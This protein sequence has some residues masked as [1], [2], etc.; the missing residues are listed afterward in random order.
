MNSD[1]VLV[2]VT[3]QQNKAQVE[4]MLHENNDLLPFLHNDNA[5]IIVA[6]YASFVKQSHV[7]FA[8]YY[9]YVICFEAQ[10]ATN[11][12]LGKLFSDSILIGFTSASEIKQGWFKDAHCVFSYTIGQAIE[13]GERKPE[14]EKQYAK[15]VEGFCMRFLQ[16]FSNVELNNGQ[17]DDV[18]FIGKVGQTR[19]FVEYKIYRNRWIPRQ[20]LDK[21]VKNMQKHIDDHHAVSLILVFGEV[22]EEYKKEIFDNESV[23]I[24]DI[25]NILYYVKKS[26]DLYDELAGLAYFAISDIV[27]VPPYGWKLDNNNINNDIDESILP[28]FKS[29]LMRCK[30]G[31]NSAQVY[32]SICEKII[33][34]LFGEEFSLCLPQHKTKDNLFRMDAICSLKGTSAFWKLLIQHYNTRFVVFEFKNYSTLLQQNLIFVTEKYLF[35]AALRNVAIIISR[36]GFSKN[37]KMAAEGYLKESGKLIL[38]ITDDDLVK[39]LDKK[40]NG[41]EPADYLMGKLESL[42]MSISK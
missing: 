23:V 2:L 24:W 40:E 26:R 29:Q 41:E 20:V 19:L 32:E 33:R 17:S 13:D 30:E 42:L 31:K 10:E 37:A 1:K 27:A 18:N 12:S 25:S 38:D 35:N 3:N 6:T 28:D 5:S 16:Q 15:A 21:A 14:N 34:Y 36:K 9:K 39:M 4:F 8:E 7:K 22:S 11:I